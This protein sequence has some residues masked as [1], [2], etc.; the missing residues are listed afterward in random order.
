M[1]VH[2]CNPSTWKAEAVRSGFIIQI[3]GGFR[4][5]TTIDISIFLKRSLRSPSPC[6]LAPS[7]FGDATWAV[8]VLQMSAL[9]SV[10]SHQL[11][12]APWTAMILYSPPFTARKLSLMRPVPSV[13]EYKHIFRRQFGAMSIQLHNSKF[14]L[15]AYILHNHGFLTGF[16]VPGTCFLLLIQEE[17]ATPCDGKP[18]LSSWPH[19]ESTKVQTAGHPDKR[20]F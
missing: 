19:L 5:Q 10:L 14:P 17:L 8:E 9:D 20:F 2:P 4:T 6:L 1:V 7:F 15:S 11:L 12:W 16:T 13:C 18:W 3:H